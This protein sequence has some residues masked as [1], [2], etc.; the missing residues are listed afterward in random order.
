MAA[1]TGA[2]LLEFGFVPEGT[3]TALCDLGN[4]KVRADAIEAL[5]RLTQDLPDGTAVLP[6]LPEF[7]GFL[8]KLLADPN[9]KV[10]WC[11]SNP[12]RCDRACFS[13]P[14]SAR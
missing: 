10:W 2:P 4:W 5:H 12:A 13:G 11:R 1:A 3:I 7:V 6:T 9:F 14:F 8:N